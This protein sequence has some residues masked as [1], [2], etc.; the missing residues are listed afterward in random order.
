L[1][2]QQAATSEVLLAVGRSDFELEPIFETVV[3]HAIRLCRADA[4][5]IFV[6]EGDHFRLACASGGSDEYRSLIAERAILWGAKISVLPAN[7]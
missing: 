6:H 3:E 4:G 5:Q 2:E 1:L 7:R